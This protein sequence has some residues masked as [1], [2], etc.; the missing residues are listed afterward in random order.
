MQCAQFTSATIFRAD[1]GG[2]WSPPGNRDRHAWSAALNLGLSWFKSRPGPA[3]I[4]NAT[5]PPGTAA[6]SG[7]LSFLF[8]DHLRSLYAN[9]LYKEPTEAVIWL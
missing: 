9:A 7:H 5:P 8:G 6:G 1:A 3:L 2:A 4:W